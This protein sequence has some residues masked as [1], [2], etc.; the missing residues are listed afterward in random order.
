MSTTITL[1]QGCRLGN[2]YEEVFNGRQTL[3]DYLATL[4]S[5]VVYSS[6]EDDLYFTNNGS[7][8]IDNETNDIIGLV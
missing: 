5:K 3:D 7:I 1:Y 8:S 6:T 4:T 2:K